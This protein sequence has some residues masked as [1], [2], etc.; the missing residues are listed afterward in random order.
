MYMY[1][2]AND[3]DSSAHSVINVPIIDCLIDAVSH[4]NG[5][6]KYMITFVKTW[7]LD[8]YNICHDFRMDF[9]DISSLSQ[10]ACLNFKK[11]ISTQLLLV[12]FSLLSPLINNINISIR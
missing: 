11:L 3:S 7:K 6:N 10:I 12:I 9:L 1:A 8:T 5:E 4:K 2:S